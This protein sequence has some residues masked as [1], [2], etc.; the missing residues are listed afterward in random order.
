MD[1][2]SVEELGKLIVE[3][4][5]KFY[6]KGMTKEEFA[7]ELFPGMDTKDAPPLIHWLLD[8]LWDY[9]FNR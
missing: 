7:E 9:F 6:R 4:T 8:R 3:E 2:L 5:K 1:K